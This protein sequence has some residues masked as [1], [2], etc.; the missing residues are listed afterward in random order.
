MNHDQKSSNA[1]DEED[2]LQLTRR[3][4]LAKS[5]LVG[6]ALLGSNAANAMSVVSPVQQAALNETKPSHTDRKKRPNLIYVFADQLRYQ[7]TGY[8]GDPL[9]YTPNIDRFASEGVDFCN[10]VASSPVCTAYRASLLTGKYTTSHGM[11][12]NELRINPNQRCFGHVLTDA[13]YQT[14]Y[15]GKWHLWANHVG[16]HYNA[17]NS[18]VPRGPYR[19]GF[20]GEWK[21]YNFHHDYYNVYYHTESPEKI[22]YGPGVFEPDAQTDF[23]IDF[24]KRASQKNESFALFL[25]W[26]PPHD[27]WGTG[28]VPQK[29]LDI[30]KDKSMPN[31]PNYLPN[32]DAPYADDWAKLSDD[33]RAQLEEWRR[34]YYGQTSALDTNLG[35]LMKTLDDLSLSDDTI[36]VFT[37]DHGE[38][39]G[40]HGRRAKNI[41]YEEA[42][43]IP[44]LMRWNG[45]IPK[46]I[47][48][49]ACLSTVD[50]M[51]TLCSLMK[52]EAPD[53]AE[54]MDLS[55]C[56]LG[57]RGH[58]PE[59]AMM[60]ICGATASWENGHEWRALRD[61]KYTYAI[62]RVDK[63]EL[64]FDNLADPHQMKNLADDPAH[65]KTLAHFRGILAKKMTALSDTFEEGSWYRDHWTD[66][67]RN[68]TA[69]AKGVFPVAPAVS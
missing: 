34:V 3:G 68:I 59:A 62:Y 14:S 5:A 56:A 33:E 21:A 52:L 49:D 10:A 16:D 32:N 38:M 55:H 64:L 54:G 66:G 51:Q 2:S 44:M 67:N 15:I 65:A 42:C 11:V 45:H 27:P 22:F 43:R 8:A 29:F 30:H 7:S 31:P 57:K 4:F 1:N 25:S 19:L 36:V 13:G 17:Q 28:N 58:E 40:A 18:F 60:E 53:T 26:G 47:K 37:S 9:A 20:E 69:S 63:K 35:R 48:S 12:S 6:M 24:V 46:G 61:K 39:F 50:I 23:A 41:F